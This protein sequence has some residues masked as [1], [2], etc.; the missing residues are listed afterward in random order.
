MIVEV[1]PGC[2][3]HVAAIV[4]GMDKTERDAAISAGVQPETGLAIVVSLSAYCRTLML[5]GVPVA[6][7][8][9]V[10]PLHAECGEVWLSLTNAGRRIPK[11]FVCVARA[12]LKAMLEIRLELTAALVCCDARA[13]RFMRFL[14]F[15]GE[16]LIESDGRILPRGVL[17]RN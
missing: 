9:V 11:T 16:A 13:V 5:D 1:V 12:E 8:G 7:W 17:R 3:G 6:I 14:G 15:K 4:A 2:E 10:G